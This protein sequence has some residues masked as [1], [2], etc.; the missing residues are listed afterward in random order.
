MPLLAPPTVPYLPDDDDCV[1]CGDLIDE[2]S[3][4]ALEIVEEAESEARYGECPSQYYPIQI[5]EVLNHTYRIVHKIHHGGFSTVWLAQDLK[6]QKIFAIKIMV[7][8]SSEEHDYQMQTAIHQTVTDISHLVLYEDAFLLHG[9][10]S[11]HF[12]FVFPF[13]GPS[14]GSLVG[15][16]LHI[17]TRMGARQ[18][19]Q[20]LEGLHKA[21][22]V[23]RDINSMNAIWGS[24]LPENLS[25]AN[26]YKILGRPQR[27]LIHATW[28]Q[29]ELVRPMQFPVTHCSN[30]IFL[31]DF[32]IT[33]PVSHSTIP[34]GLPPFEYCSP[35]RLHGAIPQFSCDMWSYMCLFSYLYFGSNLFPHLKDVVTYMGP[36]PKYLKG[37]YLWPKYSRDQWYDPNTAITT[38]L[39][40]RIR[41]QRPAMD[42]AERKLLM[43]V[44]T[45]GFSLIPE[46]RLTASQLLRDL[47]FNA[48]I[49]I[50]CG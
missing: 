35:E 50:Y 33:T 45:R 47:D 5:G 28:K 6:N 30:M 16:Q 14:V 27:M 38:S 3:D 34:D 9:P 17:S 29:A 15:K 24:T 1:D 23:H 8:G 26:Q 31:A 46:R 19:L 2:S 42:S 13:L 49:D 18:L 43:S 10:Q 37:K 36:L 32:G 4:V 22:F 39:E 20:A 40:E 48:L 25:V 41:Y 44:L 12:A 21:G 7:S 11:S